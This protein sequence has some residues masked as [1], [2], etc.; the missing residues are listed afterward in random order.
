MASTNGVVS[1]S[2]PLSQPSDLLKIYKSFEGTKLEQDKQMFT[3]EVLVAFTQAEHLKQ[4]ESQ[5]K[6]MR[7]L[8]NGYKLKALDDTGRVPLP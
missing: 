6:E 3:A 4:Y 7:A 2:Q 8:I 1:T 5:L